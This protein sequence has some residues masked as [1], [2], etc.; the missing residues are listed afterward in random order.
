[1]FNV[2]VKKDPIRASPIQQLNMEKKVYYMICI[3]VGIFWCLILVGNILFLQ[4]LID[5]IYYL[6]SLKKNYK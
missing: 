1:M 2:L 6:W 4:E 5:L 3:A